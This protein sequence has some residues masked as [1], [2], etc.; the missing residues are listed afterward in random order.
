MFTVIDVRTTEETSNLINETVRESLPPPPGSQLSLASQDPRVTESLLLTSTGLLDKVSTGYFRSQTTPRM[1]IESSC[2]AFMYEFSEAAANFTKCAVQ[3]ARPI[4]LCE[5]CYPVYQQA[6]A[7]YD[8][9]MKVN[10][11]GLLLQY[12]QQSIRDDFQKSQ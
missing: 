6:I 11:T 2:H 4:Q 10:K 3:Y 5:H 7:I 9:M 8:I 12:D 1:N